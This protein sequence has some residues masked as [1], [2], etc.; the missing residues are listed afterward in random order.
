MNGIP[1]SDSHMDPSLKTRSNRDN[2]PEP[3]TRRSMLRSPR[4]RRPARKSAPDD[5]GNSQSAERDIKG[6]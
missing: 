2:G 5:S 6:Y 3:K 4:V 1:G